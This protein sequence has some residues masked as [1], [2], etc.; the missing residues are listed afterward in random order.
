[1]QKSK[2][3]LVGSRLHQMLLKTSSTTPQSVQTY[4]FNCAKRYLKVSNRSTT[5]FLSD[6]RLFKHISSKSHFI[7]AVRKQIFHRRRYTSLPFLE[8]KFFLCWAPPKNFRTQRHL[9]MNVLKIAYS[10]MNRFFLWNTICHSKIKIKTINIYRQSCKSS[11][12]C[13]VENLK[14]QRLTFRELKRWQ[15]T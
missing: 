7:F 10:N 8:M 15:S 4:P 2:L 14:C 11:I 3:N 5:L 12:N 9:K 6:E 1:M 13:W